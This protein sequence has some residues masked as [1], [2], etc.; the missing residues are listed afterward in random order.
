MRFDGVDGVLAGDDRNAAEV[1]VKGSTLTLKIASEQGNHDLVHVLERELAY[2]RNV[3]RGDVL[4]GARTVQ[5]TACQGRREALAF[6][7]HGGRG[8]RSS[9]RPN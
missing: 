7:L 9:G 2:M 5:C 4:S 6:E 3:E 8:D 1:P